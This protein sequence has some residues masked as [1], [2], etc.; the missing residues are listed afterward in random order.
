MKG[1]AL[2]V[3]LLA[4]PVP[5]GAQVLTLNCQ[6]ESSYE[7]KKGVSETTTGGFSAVVHMNEALGSAKIEATTVGCFDYVGSS[8]EQEVVGNCERQGDMKIKASPTIN[9]ING[10]FVH[11]VVIGQSLTIFGGRC[12]VAKKLF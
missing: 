5:A 12:A 7:P 11:T 8:D 10:D 4:L 9:R 6:Y 3:A 1:L 2:T